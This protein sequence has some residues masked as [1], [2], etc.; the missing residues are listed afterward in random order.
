VTR[1]RVLERSVAERIAAGEVVERPASVVKELLEN[2][3]DAGAGQISVEIEGAGLRLIRVADDGA[4]ITADDVPLA[5]ERFSTSKI[6]YVEDLGT[7]R[8][9]GFRG[10]ALASIAAVARVTIVTRTPDAGAATRARVSGG[11]VEEIHLH[12]APPGTMVEVRD[13]FFTTPARLKFMKSHA[14]EQSLVADVVQRAAM[15]RPQ[16]AIRLAFDGREI[17]HWPKESPDERVADILVSGRDEELVTA[18]GSIPGGTMKAWLSRPERAR[19]N[20]TGQYVFVNGRPIQSALVRRAIEQGYAQLL[21]VGRFPVF[22]VF[23]DVHPGT[24]DVNVHPRKLEVRFRDESGL[25]GAAARHARAALLGSPLVRA[26]AAPQPAGLPGDG[27]M[28]LALEVREGPGGYGTMVAGRRLPVLRPVGQVLRTYLLAEGPDG[29][30]LIDQHAAHERILYERLIAAYRR[31]GVTSQTLAVPM[32][33]DLSPSQAALL[34]G[35]H[36]Q[37]AQLGFHVE[38]FGARTALLRAIPATIPGASLG[39]LLQRALAALAGDGDE[40]RHDPLERLAI[41]TAC[42]TA[43][44]AGDP[45]DAEAGAALLTDLEATED[46]FTCFH[47]RPTMIT[48]SREQLERWFLRS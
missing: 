45:L 7:I 24:I 40:P 17:A 6:T 34:A 37:L 22:A 12:G 25:F 47:G 27:S 21:P 18:S 9:Y 31:G 33:I 26:V 10:E 8:S 41:A 19:P 46:P 15:A 1:I 30:Y 14:R 2:S 32:T 38:S 42:H 16:V 39:D 35:A 48:V 4:G 13:L 23:L 11:A 29:F 5:F 28:G 3:L 36:D 20:R 43:I 44:R